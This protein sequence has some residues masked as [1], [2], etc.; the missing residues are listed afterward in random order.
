[1][2]W[3][4]TLIICFADIILGKLLQLCS[5]IQ[6]FVHIRDWSSP[7]LFVGTRLFHHGH[8]LVAWKN[9]C[10]RH[11]WSVILSTLYR[12]GFCRW[13]RLLAK[14]L[15]PELET[16]ASVAASLGL[17]LNLQKTKEDSREDEP[18]TVTVL[19]GC[20]GWRVYLS[21]SLGHSTTQKLFC[22]LLS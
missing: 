2:L 8:W 5:C 7:R 14:L 20:S 19:G 4:A 9:C 3:K 15:V 1:M 22:Y 21:C 6:I 13:C 11:E 10:Q 17:E 16:M 18:S 12:F